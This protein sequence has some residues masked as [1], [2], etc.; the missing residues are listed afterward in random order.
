MRVTMVMV[1]MLL[2]A[3]LQLRAQSSAATPAG[4]LAGTIGGGRTWD[5]EGQIGGGALVGLRAGRRLFG[6]TF[7]EVAV[8]YL[9]HDRT[10]RF[11][12]EGYTVVL[13]GSLIQRFGRGNAQPYV[14]GSLTLARHRGTFGFPEDGLESSTTSTDGGFA[15]GGG[16]AVRVGRRFEV[17]PEARFLTMSSDDDAS[18]AFA[19]WLGGRFAV[20]F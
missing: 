12:A 1:M 13:A 16:V 7:A 3:A 6:R 18:P 5:D 4:T 11:S 2:S 15:F 8:D 14:L 20:R 19:H 17:G 9:R 10:G